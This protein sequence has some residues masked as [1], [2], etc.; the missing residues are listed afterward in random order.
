MVIYTELR[1]SSR[2]HNREHV[3]LYRE[4]R[5]QMMLTSEATPTVEKGV[6]G[7]LCCTSRRD[8]WRHWTLV[9]ESRAE[10]EDVAMAKGYETRFFVLAGAAAD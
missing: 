3:G 5:R 4:S 6:R 7:G 8:Y 1:N 9:G 10:T 2:N